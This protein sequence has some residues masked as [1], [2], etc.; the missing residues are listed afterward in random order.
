VAIREIR[1]LLFL[2]LLGTLSVSVLG[3]IPFEWLVYIQIGGGAAAAGL[4]LAKG[5]QDDFPTELAKK[6]VCEFPAT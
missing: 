1:G 5:I 2:P 4:T 3:Q 6:Y